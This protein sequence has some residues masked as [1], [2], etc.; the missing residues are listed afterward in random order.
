MFGDT[1]AGW[2]RL[3]PT[4]P[5]ALAMSRLLTFKLSYA[6]ARATVLAVV[7]AAPGPDMLGGGAIPAPATVTLKP[8][9]FYYRLAGEFTRDGKPVNAPLR[10]TRLDRTLTIMAYQVTAADYQRCVLE[11][12]CSPTVS[13]PDASDRPAVK[14]SWHDAS[15]YAAWLSRRLGAT[16]RLPTD[17][18]WAFAAGSRFRDDGYAD[19]AADLAERW[20]RQYEREADRDDNL[21]TTPAAIGSFGANEN[22]VFDFAGNVWEW[23]N[24]CFVHQTLSGGGARASTANCGVRVVEGRH[25]SYMTDFI[26][27]PRTGGCAVGKPPS[28]LGFR[29]VLETGSPPGEPRL[30][31]WVAGTLRTLASTSNIREG[32]ALLVEHY[33]P[34]LVLDGS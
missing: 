12:P 5:P 28:N 31:N 26:R 2:R 14:I 18:E 9:P 1:A 25:R 21:D 33:G 30:A 13:A 15:A 17:E 32:H 6:A 4:A 29:L 23:T 34:K 22:G 19:P 8:L 20:L 3:G 16:Y 10:M 27:D 11:G 24:T 7:L